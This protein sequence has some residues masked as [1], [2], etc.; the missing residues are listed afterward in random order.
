MKDFE[1]IL[2]KAGK[3]TPTQRVILQDIIQRLDR[4]GMEG[5]LTEDAFKFILTPLKNRIADVLTLTGITEEGAPVYLDQTANTR[6]ASGLLSRLS[7]IYSDI[8]YYLAPVKEEGT[9]ER[10]G[11]EFYIN[12]TRLTSGDIVDILIYDEEA[13]PTWR[14]TAI[15][16]GKGGYFFTRYPEIPLEGATARIK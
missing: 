13:G 1:D 5:Y 11:E 8:C 4:N 10:E 3:L 9:I 2:A 12:D 16:H 7:D 6:D 15:E 14:K